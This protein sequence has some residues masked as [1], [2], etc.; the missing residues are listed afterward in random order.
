[1]DIRKINKKVFA[2]LGREKR[3][4]QYHD[5]IHKLLGI[6]VDFIN[7]DGESLRLS[8]M[9]HFNPYCTMLRNTK[10]GFAACQECDQLHARHA[11]FKHDII[12]YK[13]HAG[14]TEMFVP[15]YSDSGNYIGCMTA[16]QFF[17]ENDQYMTEEAIRKIA[18]THKL[19]P[20]I[21]SELYHQT[22]VLSPMQIEGVIEYIN[23]IGQI[24]VETHNKLLFMEHIDAPAKIPLIKKFVEKNYMNKITIE[25]TAKKFFLSPGYFSHFFKN[26]VGISFICF[27]NMY[28]ISQ[29]EEML[30]QTQRNITEIAFMTGFG[31]LSQFNRTFK[32]VKGVS[33]RTFRVKSPL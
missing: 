5:I 29:A 31:S 15:F 4:T 14:L 10:S 13:C 20:K 24:I 19:D 18:L 26:E 22:R 16:G 6:V 2:E 28:R 12:R 21:M 17:F 32:D 8:K 23:T 33:P 25:D 3:L 30:Q 11:S 9:R 7:A 27:V 1:M